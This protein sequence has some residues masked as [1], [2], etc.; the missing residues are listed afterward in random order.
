MVKLKAA[1][2]YEACLQ[3]AG[4]PYDEASRAYDEASRALDEANVRSAIKPLIEIGFLEEI[5]G[6]FKVPMLYRD[7]LEITQGKA[8]SAEP[9]VD[10]EDT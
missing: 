1:V 5:G 9:G 2:F 3:E 4:R 10:E 8:F 7:G 6:S